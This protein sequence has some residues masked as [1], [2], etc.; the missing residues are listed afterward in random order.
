MT[1]EHFSS[2][3]QAPPTIEGVEIIGMAG[4]GGMSTVYK[5]NH[6][7]LGRL[8]AI[9][10]LHSHLVSPS[11]LQRFIKE[12]RLTTALNDPNIASVLSCGTSAD[13]QPFLVMEFLDG[14]SLKDFIEENGTLPALLFK[15]LFLQILS[16]LKHAHGAGVIHRDLKPGNIVLVRNENGVLVAKIVDFGIAKLLDGENSA[17]QRLTQTGALIG[18]PSYMSPEQCKGTTTGARSDLYSV[19]CMMFEALTGRVPFEGES[20]IETLNQHIREQPEAPSSVKDKS[21]PLGFDEMVLKLLEKDPNKRYPNCES[22]MQ[23]LAAIDIACLAPP[24]RRKV[25]APRRTEQFPRKRMTGIALAAVVLSTA[26]GALYFISSNQETAFSKAVKAFDKGEYAEACNLLR[27]SQPLER[28]SQSEMEDLAELEYQLAHAQNRHGTMPDYHSMLAQ[29]EHQRGAIP[30][31]GNYAEMLKFEHSERFGIRDPHIHFDLAPANWPVTNVMLSRIYLAKCCDS[32]LEGHYD[33]AERR[34]YKS[35]AAARDSGL[36]AQEI[37][38]LLLK[39]QLD[40]VL[41]RFKDQQQSLRQAVQLIPRAAKQPNYETAS[42]LIKLESALFLASDWPGLRELLRVL[43]S[44]RTQQALPPPVSSSIENLEGALLLHDKKYKES[45]PYFNRSIELLNHVNSITLIRAQG[46]LATAYRKLNLRRG[47]LEAFNQALSV[48][49]KSFYNDPFSFIVRLEFVDYIKEIAKDD[50]ILA[51]K[52]RREQGDYLARFALSDRLDQ[53]EQSTQLYCAMEDFAQ[54]D[55]VAN[56]WLKLAR[57][58]KDKP[59]E[60]KAQKAQLLINRNLKRPKVP[61]SRS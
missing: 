34:L 38:V 25:N 31:F 5:A 40:G 46:G 43:Q 19:G 22:V 48:N 26:A 42:V 44:I 7:L 28:F 45:I 37:Q 27:S 13:G 9:K 11:D 33:P 61:N 52:L 15:D 56:N 50:P 21:L 20:A 24:K 54:A 51:K 49:A 36:V 30:M 17:V 10:A 29:L 4:K 53:L 32:I 2:Q 16:G 59:A 18:S 41:G 6:R 57:K 8:V 39:V 3:P 35:L 47:A 1:T 55:T 14:G 60:A 12:G 23:A 58:L